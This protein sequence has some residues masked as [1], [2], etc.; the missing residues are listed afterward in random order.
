MKGE[1]ELAHWVYRID[2]ETGQASVVTRELKGPNGLCF[3][4]DEKLLYII[5]SRVV[6]NRMIHVYE[7]D[8]DGR[9]IGRGLVF[10]DVG[11]GTIDGMR[12]YCDGNLQCV[13]DMG[14]NDLDHVLVF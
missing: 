11:A 5:E 13:W 8:P 3:S 1:Q 4:P 12:A 10:Y 7:M 14:N 9:G 6:P 2:G